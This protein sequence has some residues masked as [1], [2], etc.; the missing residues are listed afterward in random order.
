MNVCRIVSVLAIAALLAGCQDQP[1]G[2]YDPLGPEFK[3]GGGSGP[4]SGTQYEFVYP[5]VYGEMQSEC[6]Y[7]GA[8]PLR[9]FYCTDLADHPKFRFKVV[10][11]DADGIETPVSTGSVRFS[12]CE[13]VDGTPVDWVY[14]G[15]NMKKYRRDYQTAFYGEDA[16]VSDG[17]AEI[18]LV[19]FW[20]AADPVWGMVWKYKGDGKKAEASSG[21]RRLA[22]EGFTYPPDQ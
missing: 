9:T 21:W 18:I 17:F 13:R 2:P 3:K 20:A 14:C 5:G 6:W 15:S 10:A 1:A 12:R 4:P 7:K 8:E 22:H 16:D 11:I 19:D